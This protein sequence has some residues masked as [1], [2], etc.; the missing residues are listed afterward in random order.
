MNISRAF[1][2]SASITYRIHLVFDLT[3]YFT[4]KI[5]LKQRLWN[6]KGE[7]CMLKTIINLQ[8]LHSSRQ[9]LVVRLPN[10]TR[11]RL[12]LRHPASRIEFLLVS[13]S[14]SSRP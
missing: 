12:L 2:S 14:S 13:F 1:S 9:F 11:H 7:Q 4:P 10:L 3:N 5:S 6:R 8:N